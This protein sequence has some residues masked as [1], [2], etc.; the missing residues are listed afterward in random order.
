MTSV[1]AES[2]E[3]CRSS[4][5]DLVGSKGDYEIRPGLTEGAKGSRSL[6]REEQSSDRI[7]CD[8]VFIGWFP[9]R[10]IRLDLNGRGIP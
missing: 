6:L 8:D 2:F 10:E 1:S 4:I 9:G 5:G 3:G 7:R